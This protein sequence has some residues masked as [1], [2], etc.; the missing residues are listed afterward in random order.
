MNFSKLS[1]F[2]KYILIFIDLLS[3]RQFL[4][5]NETD[6]TNICL[7]SHFELLLQII[8][9]LVVFS[10]PIIYFRELGMSYYFI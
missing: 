7:E 5:A 4:Y 8:D 6:V 3:V 1:I 10:R 9:D 2:S